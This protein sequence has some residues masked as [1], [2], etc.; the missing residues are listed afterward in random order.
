MIKSNTELL[1]VKS[2][3]K[4]EP[5]E[6]LI[7]PSNLITDIF[8][9]LKALLKGVGITG[10]WILLSVVYLEVSILNF[11]FWENN[12]ISMQIIHITIIK[13]AMFLL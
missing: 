9:P 11:D 5:A 2:L 13:A 3:K 7:M 4:D 1:D 10:K 6:S 8:S 12:P